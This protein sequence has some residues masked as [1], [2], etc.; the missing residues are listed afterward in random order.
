[1][2]RW[3]RGRPVVAIVLRVRIDQHTH[4]APLLCDVDLDAAKV[5]A[6][7]HQND[8]AVQVDMLRRQQVKVFQAPVVGVHDLTCHIA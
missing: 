5:A 8:L 4:R 7:A 1:M 6:V 2:G 3:A